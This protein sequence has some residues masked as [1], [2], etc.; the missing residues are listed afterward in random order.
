MEKKALI[1][2]L[3]V[4]TAGWLTFGPMACTQ[5]EQ[6]TETPSHETVRQDE[7]E[8]K[9]GF[10]DANGVEIH[11]TDQGEGEPIVV[12]HGYAMSLDRMGS[13]GLVPGLVDAGYRVLAIDARGHGQSG[14]PH[15]PDQYG[16]EMAEDVVR[17]L[18]HLGLEKAHVMGYSMGG[19]IA[20]KVREIHPDRLQTAI[21]GGS[22]WLKQGDPA[23]GGMTGDEIADELEKSGTF[24][25]LLKN[26]TKN[27]QPPSTDEENERRSQNMLKGNDPKALAAVMRAWHEFAVPESNLRENDVPTIAIVGENDPL[28]VQVDAMQEV[29]SNLEVVVIEEATHGALSDPAFLESLIEFLGKHK[30]S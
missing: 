12:M 8:A 11:Y 13:A 7:A 18:D 30:L 3:M 19:S 20:N 23:L 10:F 5:A 27:R 21:V 26:F 29:M 14:K 2:M 6:E 25:L 15:D 17:L 4:L 1:P 28:K 16:V 24:V 22:G 9:E